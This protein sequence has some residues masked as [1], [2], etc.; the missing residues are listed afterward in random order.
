MTYVVADNRTQA[1]YHMELMG[2]APGT[3]K[4][5]L[6]AADVVDIV[7]DVQVIFVGTWYMRTDLDALSK[8]ITLPTGY[9]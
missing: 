1:Q 6:C 8:Y 3:W 7:G 5:V 4:Y 9:L 2:H